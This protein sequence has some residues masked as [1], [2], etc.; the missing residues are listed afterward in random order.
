MSPSP[1]RNP[2]PPD[3][4]RRLSSM[5]GWRGTV[6]EWRRSVDDWRRMI[7]REGLVTA[8]AVQGT[9]LDQMHRDLTEVRDVVKTEVADLR[10]DLSELNVEQGGER[11]TKTLVRWIV[12]VAL[13]VLVAIIAAVQ[14]ILAITGGGT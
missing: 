1:D 8:V 6:D 11:A 3:L 10:H 13:S 9:K 5:E 2:Y 4:E 12:P 7:D 14:L